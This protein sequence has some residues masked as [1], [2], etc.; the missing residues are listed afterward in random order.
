MRDSSRSILQLRCGPLTCVR[1]FV[2]GHR[3]SAD[4]VVAAWSP[5]RGLLGVA[6]AA[7]ESGIDRVTLSQRLLKDRRFTVPAGQQPVGGACRGL[8]GGLSGLWHP[9]G[10]AQLGHHQSALPLTPCRAVR[11]PTEVG[12]PGRATTGE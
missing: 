1:G 5:D 2:L 12:P 10:A 7:R 6:A 9:H 4:D 8:W 11:A 3:R